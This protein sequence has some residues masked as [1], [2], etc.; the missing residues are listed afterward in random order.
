MRIFQD[1]K[2]PDRFSGVHEKVIILFYDQLTLVIVTEVTGYVMRHLLDT[3]YD[4][5]HVTLAP[6]PVCQTLPLGL[7]LIGLYKPPVGLQYIWEVIESQ[8]N[9]V[10]S[11][12]CQQSGDESWPKTTGEVRH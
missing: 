12:I 11:V 1:R 4:H 5:T 3:E 8:D 7:A 6:G 2:L 10:D 9:T